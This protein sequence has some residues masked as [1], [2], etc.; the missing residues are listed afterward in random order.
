MRYIALFSA[1]FF[2][3]SV[4]QAQ[5]VVLR[6]ACNPVVV[7]E[8]VQGAEYTPGVDVHGNK[9]VGA[10]LNEGVKSLSYPIVIPVEID[11][12]RFLDL[13]IP[14]AVDD[15]TEITP[16]VAYFT[17]YED[18]KVEYNGQDISSMVDHECVEGDGVPQVG[19]SSQQASQAEENV[20]LP[21]PEKPVLNK[22]AE[23]PAED[24]GQ[25]AS[26]SVISGE[27]IEGQSP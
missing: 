22:K 19:M 7:N 16:D 11:I 10:D 3:A 24:H 23:K 18:G 1:L 8:D 21:K 12:I 26:D 17:L 25:K 13:K 2:S 9:V 27:K 14:P 15:A 6:S 20:A 5:D 4:A